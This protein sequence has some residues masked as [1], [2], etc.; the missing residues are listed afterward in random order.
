VN[1]PA[2]RPVTADTPDKGVARPSG[3]KA[4][5]ARTA[6]PHAGTL[7]VRFDPVTLAATLKA[8]EDKKRND[9]Q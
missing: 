6:D 8:A 2:A 1:R 5:S 9:R 7:V 4:T 3:S